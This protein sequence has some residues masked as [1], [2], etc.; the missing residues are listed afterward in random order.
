M[1]SG[2]RQTSILNSRSTFFYPLPIRN[3]RN[4]CGKMGTRKS[5][6]TNKKGEKGVKVKLNEHVI[7]V[8]LSFFYVL[9]E[10]VLFLIF[11][12][13]SFFL[14]TELNLLHK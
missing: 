1:A 3:D 13:F 10:K 7:L 4:T 5:F 6:Q 2:V 12:I 11:L 14:F 9:I 8:A